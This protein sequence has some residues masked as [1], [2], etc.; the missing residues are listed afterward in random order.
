MTFGIFRPLLFLSVCCAALLSMPAGLHAADPE[1]KSDDAGWILPG[2]SVGTGWHLRLKDAR[3]EAA[4][5]GKPILIV[6]S[7]PDWSSAS[8]RFESSVLRSK[9]YASAVQPAVIGLYI[10]QFVNTDAPEEQVSANQSLR[11]ALGVPAV[12][13]CTIILASD[14]KS[15]LGMIP[16]APDKKAF[17]EQVSKLAGIS[18]AQ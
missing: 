6:F 2:A 4:K 9:E 12:Y 18:P 1:Q 17:I 13:P 5:D 7:G 8:K 16:G 11:K 10:Q 3:V 15:I 14:G